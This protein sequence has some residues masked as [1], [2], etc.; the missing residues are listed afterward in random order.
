MVQAALED[1]GYEVDWEDCDNNG[2]GA[3][4]CDNPNKNPR[5][6]TD[7]NLS[8]YDAILF[9]NSSWSWAGGEQAGPLLDQAQRDALIR[10]TQ[11]SG[12]IAAVHNMTDSKHA[13]PPCGTGGTAG[14][15]AS[16]ARR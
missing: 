5:I 4:N 10:F 1:A 13:A 6:F 9:L 15:T 8:R 3:N 2:G 11:N 12:G 16:S 7:E 14:R